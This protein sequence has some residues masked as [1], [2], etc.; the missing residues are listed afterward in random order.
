MGILGIKNRTENWK[1]ARH[2]APFLGAEDAA[3]AARATLAQRLGEPEETSGEAIRIELFWRGIR[4]CKPCNEDV[5]KRYERLFPDL[6]DKVKD[7]PG[8][9]S[10]DYAVP[11]EGQG[12]KL[13]SNL[14]HTEIDIVL[15]TPR[16]LFIGEA[17]D[18]SSPG[19]NGKY[20]LVHQL[21]RQY[22]TARIL[23]DL[24]DNPN[25]V[26]TPFAVVDDA[27]RDEFMRRRQVQFMIQHMGLEN[28]LTWDCIRGLCPPR[29]G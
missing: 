6:R 22:V 25:R 24:S 10:C 3:A 17:K 28:I 1:T 15:E 21:I 9:K 27:R 20:V 4:D 5:R 26:V 7:F 14:R 18:E 19:T 23:V 29:D 16:H 2:F 12:H 13:F 8:F 11:K